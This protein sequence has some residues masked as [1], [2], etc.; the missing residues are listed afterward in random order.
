MCAIV[1]GFCSLVYSYAVPQDQT[2]CSNNGFK[3]EVKCV[4]KGVNWTDPSSYYMTFQSCPVEP[5]DFTN[6][7]KFEVPLL[8]S[9]CG[10]RFL[11]ADHSV[12]VARSSS[13]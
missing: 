13:C 2:Y 10:L 9:L 5:G 3:Q 11:F 12:P 6:F 8:R 4:I 7:V 1:I